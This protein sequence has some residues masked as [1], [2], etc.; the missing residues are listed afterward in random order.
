M[1]SRQAM[2]NLPKGLEFYEQ[3]LRIRKAVLGPDHHAVATTLWNM[4]ALFKQQG[5]KARAKEALEKAL[6]IFTLQLGKDHSSTK[7]VAKWLADL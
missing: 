2:G 7:G 1:K 5:D 6:R 4:G 3:A